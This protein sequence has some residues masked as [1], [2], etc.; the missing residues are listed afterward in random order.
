MSDFLPSHVLRHARF[1]CPSLSP[2]VYLNSRKFIELVMLSNLF[3]LSRLLFLP[4]I[5]SSIWDISCKSAHHIRWPKYWS[6]SFSES[7]L[8][9]NIQGWFPLVLSG[10]TSLQSKGLPRVFSSITVWKHNSSALS[11]LY[12][13][14][15]TSVHHYWK[16]HS[17]DYMNLC[18]QRISF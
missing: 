5:F 3:I 10:L 2:T 12:G 18:G 8:S 13:P 14:T 15:L 9:M 11:L 7:V 1:P 4:S 17:F 6:F 16:S